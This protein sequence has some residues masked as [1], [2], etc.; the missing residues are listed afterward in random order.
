MGYR[1]LF[2]LTA[3]I[4]LP[5]T[6]FGQAVISAH[7]GVVHFSEGSVVIDGQPLGQKFASFPSI[8]Q[9]SALRTEEGRAEV[10]LTPGVLLRV[11]QN[12]AIRMQSISL[13]DTKVEFL[14]GSVIIDSTQAASA[15]PVVVIDKESQIRFP[16]PG[17]Y[18]VDFEPALLQVYSGEAEVTRDGKSM[19]VDSSHLYFLTMGL[20]TR[21]IGDGTMDDFYQWSSSRSQTDTADDKLAA[22][23]PDDP[24]DADSDDDD[25]S[26]A[27]PAPLVGVPGYNPLGGLPTYNPPLRGLPPE[28]G[29]LGAG[30]GAPLNSPLFDPYLP[31]A[32]RSGLYPYG[33]PGL[34]AYPIAVIPLYLHS[35][36]YRSNPLYPRRSNPLYPAWR[37]R[38]GSPYSPLRARPPIVGVTRAPTIPRPVFPVRRPAMGTGF[39][40]PSPNVMPRTATPIR[41]GMSPIHPAVGM[42]HGGMRGR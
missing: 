19:T 8:K 41:P 20:D 28:Y 6:G 38:I 39:Y 27:D 13:S 16:K 36:R 10:L 22:G 15:E 35:Y 40:R 14:Q 33:M 2:V 24:A 31:F 17:T 29:S 7:S 4:A 37:Q 42:P 1:R 26:S 3:L 25:L 30:I 34:G 9:G 12:S 18:R 11:D 5:T 21:K 23:I 32:M